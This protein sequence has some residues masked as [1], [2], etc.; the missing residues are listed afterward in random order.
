VVT[1]LYRPPP[2]EGTAS[3]FTNHT[4]LGMTQAI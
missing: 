4:K 3:S 1:T 2:S